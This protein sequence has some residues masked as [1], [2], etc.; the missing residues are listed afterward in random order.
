[1]NSYTIWVTIFILIGYFIVTD[2]S[3]AKAFYMVTQLVRIYYEKTKWWIF[4]N[5]KNPII[6]YIMWRRAY[7]LAEELQKEFAEKENKV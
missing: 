4:Y 2:N 5:P 6:K 1:M 7:K 3:V